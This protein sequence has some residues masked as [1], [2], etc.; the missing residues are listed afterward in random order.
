MSTILSSA[1]EHARNYQSYALI[2][3]NLSLTARGMPPIYI[4]RLDLLP[5]LKADFFTKVCIFL[6][7]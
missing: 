3:P 2:G 4:Y 6:F 1:I 5:F 7:R